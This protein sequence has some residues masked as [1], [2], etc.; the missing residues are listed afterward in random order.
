[1]KEHLWVIISNC[2][3]RIDRKGKTIDSVEDAMRWHGSFDVEKGG[4]MVYVHENHRVLK[5][6]NKDETKTIFELKIHEL[7]TCIHCSHTNNDI[8]IV[9]RNLIKD[10]F[11]ITRYDDKFEKSFK[12]IEKG[13]LCE[14]WP[15]YITENTNGDIVTSDHEK[16]AVVAIDK[17]GCHRFEYN[18]LY[19]DDG[20]FPADICT[21]NIGRILV[22][23]IVKQNVHVLDENGCFLAVLFDQKKYN[24]NWGLCVDNKQN[25]YVEVGKSRIEAYEYLTE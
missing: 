23:N 3:V 19:S 17:S 25:V 11:K 2:L 1:M 6:K 22:V 15:V 4:C 14:K 10:T 8:L 7:I 18:G 5:R 20:F 13:S 16:E 24:L 21:D 9:I 12:V